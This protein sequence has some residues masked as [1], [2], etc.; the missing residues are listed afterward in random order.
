MDDVCGDFCF[1]SFSAKAKVT[2]KTR[3]KRKSFLNI[4]KKSILFYIILKILKK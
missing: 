3:V 2:W 4:R 1:F